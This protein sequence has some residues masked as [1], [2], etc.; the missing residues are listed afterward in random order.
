MVV[1][2]RLVLRQIVQ[3]V[4]VMILWWIIFSSIWFCDRNGMVYCYILFFS[5]Q[6]ISVQLGSIG[7]SISQVMWFCVFFMFLVVVDRKVSSEVL[8]SSIGN[9]ISSICSIEL[10]FMLNWWLMLLGVIC[11]F[12]LNVIRVSSSDM[13]LIMQV[14]V[15]LLLM[16]VLC[17]FGVVSSG[18]SDCCLCLL[19]VVFMIRQ[20]LLMNEVSVSSIGSSIDRIMLCL[21]LVLVRFW[22]VMFS[23]CVICVLMLCVIRCKVLIWLL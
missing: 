17:E 3:I 12:I 6:V 13:K 20:V 10:M 8:I 15:I 1:R 9:I 7:S 2:L 5:G 11:V 14:V 18:F 4:G 16:I 22:C 21:V 19:V 23:G